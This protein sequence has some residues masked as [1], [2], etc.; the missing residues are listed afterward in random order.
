MTSN[1]AMGIVV[2]YGGI[3]PILLSMGENNGRKKF[4]KQ[5]TQALSDRAVS[6]KDS[7]GAEI[8]VDQLL[9]LLN[10]KYKLDILGWKFLKSRA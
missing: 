3:L 7:Q 8:T 9:D 10:E 1:L 2:I 5:L 4:K 6:M